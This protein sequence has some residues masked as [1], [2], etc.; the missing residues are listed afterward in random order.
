M[1]YSKESTVGY[2]DLKDIFKTEFDITTNVNLDWDVAPQYVKTLTVTPT[3]LTQTN[4]KIG[5]GKMLLMTGA[6]SYSIEFCDVIVDDANYDGALWNLFQIFQ[7][8]WVMILPGTWLF[9]KK[10]RS[11]GLPR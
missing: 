4:Y 7:V 6:F 5:M 9:L 8:F 1:G 11:S 2:T 3:A 10:K